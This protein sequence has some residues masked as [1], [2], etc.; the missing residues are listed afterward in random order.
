MKTSF[1]YGLDNISSYF[2]K[3]AL[4][5]LARPLEYL[6]NFSLQSGIFP[7][8]SKTARVA[9]VYK[10]GSKEEKSNY[11]PISVL[12]VLTRLFENVVNKQLY[13]Y[14][15]KNEHIYRQQSGFRSLLSVVTCLI[16]NTNDWYFHFD[17]GMCTG[18]VFG[19]LKK[20]FDT[21]DHDILLGKLSHYGT[22]NTEDKWFSSYLG[23]RRQCYRVNGIT[24]NV[25]NITCGVP[26]VSC[27]GPLLFLLYIN[28]LSFALKCSKVTMYA[29]DTSLAHSAKDV[30][31]IAG[32]MNIELENPK[33]WLHGNSL[34]LHIDKTTSML[35]GTR[36]TINDKVTTE[37]LRANFVISGEPIE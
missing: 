7:D 28:D 9:P 14:L 22:K 16:S 26:Q 3:L 33:V 4:P 36:H 10:E 17:Q 37:P 6:F 18:I 12:S 2:S 20:A 31:D 27:F 24:S 30:K 11:R 19:D 34:S 15:D 32:T 5:F 35:I 1:G 8:S 25:E 29:Y 13:D 23:N 21:V